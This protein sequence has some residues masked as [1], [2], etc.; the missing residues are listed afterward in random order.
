MR[1]TALSVLALAAVLFG[2]SDGGDDLES[3]FDGEVPE[4][5]GTADGDGSVVGGG[6]VA[7]RPNDAISPSLAVDAE[8]IDLLDGA[9]VVSGVEAPG[10]F[11][12]QA[13]LDEREGTVSVTI[14]RSSLDAE[15]E[16]FL[17]GELVPTSVG[18]ATFR[19]DVGSWEVVSEDDGSEGPRVRVVFG[20]PTDLQERFRD[21]PGGDVDITPDPGQVD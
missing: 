7:Q 1:R 15:I 9:C 21:D 5:A 17:D 19:D 20:C 16:L 3:G 8:A 14:D 6:D 10:V 12:F 18:T 11:S 4:F 2:C 13:A